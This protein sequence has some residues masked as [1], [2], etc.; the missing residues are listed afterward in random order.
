MICKKNNIKL[1]LLLFINFL[2]KYNVYKQ[3]VIN[4]EDGISYR[5]M[6]GSEIDDVKYIVKTIMMTPQNLILEAFC[7]DN[8]KQINWHIIHKKWEEMVWIFSKK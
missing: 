7:W 6:I 1:I 8:D 5:Q 2:K 4:L 3:Y